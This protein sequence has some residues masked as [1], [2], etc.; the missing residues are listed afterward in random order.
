MPVTRAQKTATIEEISKLFA[1]SKIVVLSDYRGIKVEDITTLRRNVRKAK[2]Q[3]K[4]VKNTLSRRVISDPKYQALR[5]LLK[6]PIGLTFGTED[7]V[8]L[9]KKLSEFAKSNDKFQLRAGLMDGQVFD[10]AALAMLASL[11]SRP[12]LMAQI[13]GLFDNPIQSLMGV[14][15]ANIR[16]FLYLLKGMEEKAQSETPEAPQGEALPGETAAS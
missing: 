15:D 4:V 11:P 16:D 9:L 12:V 8:E 3:F 1:D 14:M 7:P 13:L 6:G 5:D 2:G 10:R